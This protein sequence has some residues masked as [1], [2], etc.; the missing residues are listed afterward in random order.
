MNIQ[1]TNPYIYQVSPRL[2]LNA[3]GVR[4]TTYSE[5]ATENSFQNELDRQ[6]IGS[7]GEVIDVSKLDCIDPTK[8][9]FYTVEF[10]PDVELGI[11]YMRSCFDI[12]DDGKYNK[13]TA[14]E[15]FTGMSRPEIYKAIYEKYQNCYGENFYYGDAISYPIPPSDYDDYNKIIRRFDKE[16]AAALGDTEK[17]QAARREALY[18]DMSDYEVRRAIIGKYDLSDGLTFRELYQL[19]FDIWKVGLDGGFHN[20]LDDLFYDFSTAESRANCD[21]IAAREK[22]LDTKVTGYYFDQM[23]KFY[24]C[25]G[26]QILPEY[27]TTLSQ[28]IGA[29]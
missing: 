7:D 17:V 4:V 6:I 3:N 28:I 21:N 19:S 25:P 9:E 2:N 15:D 27:Y 13:L 14:E 22:Y 23:E 26:T 5:L 24:H 18:G 12:V 29:L 20:R 8:M 11:K 1:S 16:V 10:E